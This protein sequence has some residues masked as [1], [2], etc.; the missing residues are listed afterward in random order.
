[1][2][3]IYNFIFVHIPLHKYQAYATK[4]PRVK[5]FIRNLT[6]YA[7]MAIITASI[8]YIGFTIAHVFYPRT[9]EATPVTIVKEV[10]KKSAVMERIADCESGKRDKN[11]KA[12]KGSA[13]HLDQLTGQVYTKA[14][15]NKT[16]DI[17]KYM[18]NEYYHGT[19]HGNEHYLLIMKQ[20]KSIS[21]LINLS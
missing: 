3:K 2:K 1:M 6:R 5:Y 19:K 17:G 11:G 16:V 12:I 8:L 7:C 10:I 9:V 14:N 13:S 21:E 18:I 15:E 4:W 20:K